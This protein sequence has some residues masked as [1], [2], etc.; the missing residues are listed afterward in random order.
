MADLLDSH[1]VVKH[2][3]R[4]PWA[5]SNI[6]T[7][8]ANNL[9]FVKNGL[10]SELQI[11]MARVREQIDVVKVKSSLFDD[12]SLFVHLIRQIPNYFVHVSPS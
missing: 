5:I 6:T 9:E 1:F 4:Q 8:T 11:S 7:Q 2:Q 12:D 10:L 3:D